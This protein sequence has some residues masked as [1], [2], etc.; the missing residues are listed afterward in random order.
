MAESSSNANPP[1]R[2][3]DITNP[4][5]IPTAPFVEDVEAFVDSRADI[6]PNLKKFQEMIAKYQFMEMNTQRRAAGL[7][8]KIPD[9]QKTLDTVT[10]LESRS[11]SSKAIDATFE[12]NDTLYAKA[13]I[14]ATDEVYLWLGANVMLSYPVDEARK[15]LTGKLMAAKESLGNCEE[16]LD[17]L[18]QQIT[19]LE[20][21]TARLYNYEVT[22]KRKEKEEAE[23]AAEED[24]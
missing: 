14:N 20:V 24:K 4:R 5:G 9:I 17:F 18:R 12:L 7:K 10:F 15:L 3:H 11:D 2:S 6:E 22:L 16:D 8:D 21:N 1:P 23:K 19:T 13:K